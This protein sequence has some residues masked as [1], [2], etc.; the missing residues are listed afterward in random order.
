MKNKT[1]WVLLGLLGVTGLSLAAGDRGAAPQMT[2]VV[3]D[4][5]MSSGVV[6]AGEMGAGSEVNAV[7]P[8]GSQVSTWITN[9]L[10]YDPNRERRGLSLVERGTLNDI[11]SK[12]D[13]GN[14]GDVEYETRRQVL[15]K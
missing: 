2:L 12:F 5:A 8:K 10:A 14:M 4:G 3:E 6:Q 15:Q 13:H 11:Q 9:R 1:V 7:S